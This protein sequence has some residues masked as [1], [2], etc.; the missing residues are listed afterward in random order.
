ME[1]I[2]G[3][4]L[5]NEPMSIEQKASLAKAFGIDFNKF[6]K[7]IMNEGKRKH[8]VKDSGTTK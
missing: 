4:K 2:L 6:M 1:R 8:P 7:Q 5:R 3:G